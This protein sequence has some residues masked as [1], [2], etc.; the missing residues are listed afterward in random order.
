MQDLVIAMTQIT[1]LVGTHRACVHAIALPPS[2]R[3]LDQA[4]RT[5]LKVAKNFPKVLATAETRLRV[6]E[7]DY[8]QSGDITLGRAVQALGI[9]ESTGKDPYAGTQLMLRLQTQRAEI[10]AANRQAIRLLGR[11]LDYNSHWVFL[12]I[13]LVAA[14]ERYR[15]VNAARNIAYLLARRLIDDRAA[16]YFAG[17]LLGGH[18]AVADQFFH[19]NVGHVQKA[20]DAVLASS[21]AYNDYQEALEVFRFAAP[22][23][24]NNPQA[25]KVLCDYIDEVYKWLAEGLNEFRSLCVRAPGLGE[26]VDQHLST[27]ATSSILP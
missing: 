3:Q 22:M 26:L 6:R 16:Y 17:Q 19:V 10:E 5:N 7:K 1:D 20:H 21:I 13:R 4:A 15:Q 9:Y 12:V 27:Q 14:A 25:L 18:V 8:K 2:K 23:Y 11:I 24:Q